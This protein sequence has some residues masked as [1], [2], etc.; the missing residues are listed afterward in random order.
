MEAMKAI[1]KSLIGQTI[2]MSLLPNTGNNEE[3]AKNDLYNCWRNGET[4]V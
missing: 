4:I 3:S 2:D 1:K